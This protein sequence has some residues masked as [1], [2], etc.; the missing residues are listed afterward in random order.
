[1]FMIAALKTL[2]TSKSLVRFDSF[3]L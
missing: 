2:E 1:V 3:V